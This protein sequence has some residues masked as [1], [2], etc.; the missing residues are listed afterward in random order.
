[1]NAYSALISDKPEIITIPKRK[2]IRYKIPCYKKAYS[3]YQYNQT[4]YYKIYKRIQKLAL[5]YS[6]DIFH[7]TNPYRVLQVCYVR[8]KAGNKKKLGDEK[9]IFRTK[10]LQKL[11]TEIAD[12]L[13]IAYEL[14]DSTDV[15]KYL[16]RRTNLILYT[17]DGNNQAELLE[18]INKPLKIRL[19]AH[20]TLLRQL[21][22]GLEIEDA[23]QFV[24]DAHNLNKS[25]KE[26]NIFD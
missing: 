24:R 13:L 25:Q 12:Y 21:H 8:D 1:M 19:Q 18:T 11:L 14:Q 26:I 15:L 7:N 22:K 5:T 23:V 9:H 10:T 17:E 4:K 20:I 3:V 2:R 16:Y 6:E